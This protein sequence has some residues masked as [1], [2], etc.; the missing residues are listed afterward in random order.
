MLLEKPEDVKHENSSGTVCAIYGVDAHPKL[1]LFATAGGDNSVKIWSL[2]IQKKTE[3]GIASFELL[4]TLSNHQQAVNCVRWAGHGRYLASGS[5]DQLILLYELQTGTLAPVPFGSNARPNKQNWVHCATLE[6]HTMDVADI[7]WSPDDRMLATC[8]IDNTIL[9]W[10]VS[11][12]GISEVMTQPLQTLTGHNGWVKGV[13]WDP[14]GKY[15]S[16]AGEDKTVRMWKV[17]DWQESDVVK[18]PFEGCASTSHFR[19]LSWSPDGSVLCATHA[20]SSKKNIAALLNR[21]SWTND[22]KFVGHQ[23]V[24]TSARFNPKLL[25]TTADPD[26]EFACCAVGGED[27]TVSIWLAHLARPLAVIKDCFD[28]SVTDLSW[29]SSQSLLLACS[30]DGTVCCFQFDADEIGTPISDAQQSKLLQAKYGSRAGI[31]LASTLVEG[32]IQL[33]LEEKSTTLPRLAV[34]QPF[35][36]NAATVANHTTNTLIP[37]RKRADSQATITPQS[38]PPSG[39]SNGDKKR[40][41]P[42]LLPTNVHHSANNPASSQNSIRNIL[43]PTV[44]SPSSVTAPDVT[45][46]DTRMTTTSKKEVSAV[47]ET[48]ISPILESSTALSHSETI[49]LTLNEKP[50]GLTTNDAPPKPMKVEEKKNGVDGTSLKRKRESERPITQATAVLA[51]SREV[52][53]RAS[54]L[55]N[56]RISAGMTKGV[57]LLPEFP[58][59]LLFSVEIDMKTQSSTLDSILNDNTR[60]RLVSSKVV[61]EVV[62]HNLKKLQSEEIIELGSLYSTIKCSEGSELKWID[63]VPGRAVCVVG[64]ARYCAVGV[65]NGDLFILSSNGRRLFPCI[66]L[67]SAISVMECS[68]SESPYLLV[69][70]GTGDLKVW[71][72]AQRKLILSSSIEAI[73]TITPEEDRK[74]T[75]LR[76]QVTKKGMPLIT[77]AE[78]NSETKGN[79]SLLSYTFDSAMSSWMRVADDS[80]VYSDFA[81]ALSTDAVTVKSVPIGPLRQLQNASG[82]GRSQRGIASAMLSGMSDP[83]MQRNL[84]RSHLEHQA[85]AAIVLKSSTEYC[86]WIQTYA[87]FLTNDEDVTRL[88]ELCA[89]MMGPFHASSTRSS[90]SDKKSARRG[91]ESNEWDPMVLDLVKRDVL[92]IHILPTIAMNRALQRIVTKYQLMLS[93]IDSREKDDED[94]NDS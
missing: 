29:S 11:V 36:G 70:L 50:V 33:Q 67:G 17:A 18:E 59:R 73:T 76:C 34:S 83:L 79:S 44:V 60:S 24:V 13:A 62:V 81:S 84:T 26:K 93:E 82:Y 22:L 10:N 52:V 4:V 75:L 77:F 48:N 9:I 35:G 15:L 71:D 20:F 53:A 19:R 3:E 61:I 28:S 65:H 40:I 45:L 1:Q 74:L 7:A 64:N 56:E 91:N 55:L 30:L 25:V 85:A 58:V 32:P 46:L 38:K 72:F 49:G 68:K 12:G 6:R 66:A 57:Q 92:K 63:R 90:V 43:G 47:R 80:F 5:D 8:S 78:S 27:A 69:I 31:T 41:A 88:D 21:G 42:V 16:S 89:E 37:K 94:D 54:K 23:G 14:V 39:A 51:N 2:E 87:R 86:Y